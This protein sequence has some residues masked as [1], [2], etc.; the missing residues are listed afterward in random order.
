MSLS[1]E[2]QKKREKSGLSMQE[3]SDKSGVPLAT[4]KRIFSG[5]TPDP[6]YS[7]VCLLL[8]TMGVDDEPSYPAHENAALIDLYERTIESKNKWIKTLLILCLSLVGIFIFILFWDICNPNI[9]F[10]R[11]KVETLNYGLLYF[12]DQLHG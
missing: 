1:E 11:I 4:V 10:F 7:T 8:A 6:G 12:L 5:Q 9:G 2:L 3:L